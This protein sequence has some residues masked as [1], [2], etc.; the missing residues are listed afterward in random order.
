MRLV[1]TIDV[2]YNLATY[3]R[4][5]GLASYVLIDLHLDISV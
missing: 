5:T 4:V 2:R 1:D 3:R